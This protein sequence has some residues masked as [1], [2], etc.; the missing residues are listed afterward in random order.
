MTCSKCHVTVLLNAL[1]AP[2][3]LRLAALR[4]VNARVSG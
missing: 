1:S 2:R 4:N 3:T